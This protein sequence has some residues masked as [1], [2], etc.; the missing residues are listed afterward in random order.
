M[1]RRMFV[2]GCGTALTGLAGC[3][4]FENSSKEPSEK[5]WEEPAAHSASVSFSEES[6]LGVGVEV[7]KGEFE[8]I[9]VEI[10]DDVNDDGFIDGGFMI[11]EGLDRPSLYVGNDDVS[12]AGDVCYKPN[13]DADCVDGS[14]DEETLNAFAIS[15]K[16]RVYGVY[17]GEKTLLKRYERN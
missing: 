13:M 9:W 6:G 8:Y 15:A 4:N 11:R 17:E 12:I 16:I 2:L 7:S 10:E 14:L 5:H 3:L 1:K